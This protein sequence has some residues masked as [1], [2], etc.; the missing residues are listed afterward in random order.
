MRLH[1]STIL[2]RRGP[3]GYLRQS[4]FI[5]VVNKNAVRAVTVS[6]NY[7]SFSISFQFVATHGRV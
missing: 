6:Q 1:G 2:I 4:S 7:N 3:G 5:D